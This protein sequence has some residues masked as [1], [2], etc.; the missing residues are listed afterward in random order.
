LPQAKREI[1]GTAGHDES[2]AAARQAGVIVRRRARCSMPSGLHRYPVVEADGR[3]PME[4]QAVAK[5]GPR[6][7]NPLS[8]RSRPSAR[9]LRLVRQAERFVHGE[10]SRL[11]TLPRATVWSTR[12]DESGAQK[13]SAV[14]NMCAAQER[15]R[16]RMREVPDSPASQLNA[17]D[18]GR[19][20]WAL[21]RRK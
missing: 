12:R 1:V 9:S 18:Q 4:R 2:C 14:Q 17:V 6:N 20:E 15:Q 5:I 10:D 21:R 19:N 7:E 11:K 3:A 16:R 8:R 13:E